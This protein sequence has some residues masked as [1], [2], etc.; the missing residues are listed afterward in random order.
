MKRQM[1]DVRWKMEDV[2]CEMLDGFDFPI[3]RL[4]S[5]ISRPAGGC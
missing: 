3:S 2:R 4:T 1:L 5:D